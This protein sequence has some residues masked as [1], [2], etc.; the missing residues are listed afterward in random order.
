MIKQTNHRIFVLLVSIIL[1]L[2]LFIGII[3]VNPIVKTQIVEVPKEV[4]KEVIIEVEKEVEVIVEKEVIKEVIVEVEKEPQYVYQITSVERELLARIVYLEANAEN[5]E[6]QKAIASVIINR[7][8]SGQWGDTLK[9]VIY[10]K[11]EFSPA[12]RIPNTT[13]NKYQYEAVDY[14]LKNGCTVPE[15][16]LYFR[17]SHHHQWNGYEPYTIIDRTY[18]GY[19][20]KDKK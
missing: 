11:G 18:F 3:L 15:Y 13:P 2:L 12:N 1:L 10:A 20:I 8:Q 14:V 7:W 5:L 19:F 17:A 9:D 4:I 16:V 6:C